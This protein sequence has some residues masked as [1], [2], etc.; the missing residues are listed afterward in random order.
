MDQV[1]QRPSQSQ[2]KCDNSEST[3]N[4][5]SNVSGDACIKPILDDDL[6]LLEMGNFGGGKV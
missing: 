5:K 1:P 6:G 2:R 3:K 4:K